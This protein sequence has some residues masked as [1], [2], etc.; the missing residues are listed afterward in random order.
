[1]V[2][3][4]NQTIRNTGAAFLLTFFLSAITTKPFHKCKSLHPEETH[5][6]DKNTKNTADPYSCSICEFEMTKD[7][8]AIIPVLCIGEPATFMRV[9]CNYLFPV[10]TSFSIASDNKG[11]PSLSLT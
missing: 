10:T 11:P 8:E 9:S 6:T 3:L 1:M 2:S 4:C 5:H 7:C